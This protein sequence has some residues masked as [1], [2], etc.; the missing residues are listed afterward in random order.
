MREFQYWTLI[1]YFYLPN[2]DSTTQVE[3]SLHSD[4]YIEHFM[5]FVLQVLPRKVT[6]EEQGEILN[7][8]CKVHELEVESILKD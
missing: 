3:K 5:I 6:T 8:L 1:I 2:T 7:M 4:F